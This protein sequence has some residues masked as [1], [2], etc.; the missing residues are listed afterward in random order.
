VLK[1]GVDVIGE[2]RERVIIQPTY[3]FVA[4]TMGTYQTP[5]AV[6]TIEF[7]GV[8]KTVTGTG[9][10]F[11]ANV[12]PGQFILDQYSWRYHEIEFVD[13]NTVLRLKEDLIAAV[14]Y[15]HT[16]NILTL[17]NGVTLRDITIDY[18]GESSYGVWFEAVQNG[19][20]ENVNVINC[21]TTGIYL[22]YCYDIYVKSTTLHTKTAN[23]SIKNCYQCTFENCQAQGPY[24]SGAWQGFYI[25]QSY[26]CTFINCA[27]YAG[28]GEGFYLHQGGLNVFKGCQTQ[29]ILNDGFY[30]YQST[31]NI[32]TEARNWWNGQHGIRLTA[33]SDYNIINSCSNVVNT[34]GAIHNDGANNIVTDNI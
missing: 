30:L 28:R 8:G 29:S 16:Y 18:Q 12:S 26:A 21:L 2:N 11:L 13:S 25:Y 14:A 34:A 20:I 7:S 5:Y 31:Y 32:I 1:E 24:T 19:V 6:G 3:G 23:F 15:A 17:V 10:F 33:G 27:A 4:I 9:T 22:R